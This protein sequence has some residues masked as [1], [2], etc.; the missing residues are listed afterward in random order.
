MTKRENALQ[1]IKWYGYH[2]KSTWQI[3]YIENRISREVAKEWYFK[4]RDARA[5]GVKCTCQEC[6]PK[7]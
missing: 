1:L 2:E 3:V 7:P 4:G 5:A 6:N